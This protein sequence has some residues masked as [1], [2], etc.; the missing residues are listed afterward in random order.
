[1]EGFILGL[2]WLIDREGKV[3]LL[4][5]NYAKKHLDGH[6]IHGD[7]SAAE[8]FFNLTSDKVL[9]HEVAGKLMPRFT[10]EKD[11]FERF[12]KERKVVYKTRVGAMGGGVSV[13]VNLHEYY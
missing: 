11:K 12:T 3:Y 6:N 9:L 7:Y 5:T 13:Q 2:D 1:M 10:K 8:H 4:E